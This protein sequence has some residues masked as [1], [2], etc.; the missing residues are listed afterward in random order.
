MGV[1]HH[2]DGDPSNNEPSNLRLVDTG[3]NLAGSVAL[4]SQSIDSRLTAEEKVTRDAIFDVID[5][6]ERSLWAHPSQ[7]VSNASWAGKAN[8]DLEAEVNAER[9]DFADAVIARIRTLKTI[10][11]DESIRERR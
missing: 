10:D 8:A 6:R 1:I 4:E 7:G 2:I 5:S 3:E 11:L 9:L